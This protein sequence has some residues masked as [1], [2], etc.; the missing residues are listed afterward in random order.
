ML[1]NTYRLKHTYVFHIR[2][3]SVSETHLIYVLRYKSFMRRVQSNDTVQ[4][5]SYKEHRMFGLLK[6]EYSLKHIIHW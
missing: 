3:Q 1:L 5:L 2:W 6:I 4:L